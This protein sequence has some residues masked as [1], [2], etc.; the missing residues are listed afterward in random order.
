[1]S[2][3]CL[4]RGAVG[5]AL[6]FTLVAPTLARSA[7]K[8][9]E[10]VSAF[11]GTFGYAVPI[12]VPAFRGLE[13]RLGLAYTSEGRNGFAGVGWTLGGF[14]TVE[15]ANAGRGTPRFD[16]SDIY[17]LDGQE[18]LACTPTTASPSCTTGGTHATKIESYQRIKFDSGSNSWTATA[19]DGT[20][21]VFNPI[22]TTPHGTLRWG[23]SQRIDT[24]GNAVN[25]SWACV[26][27]DCYP[28]SASYNGYGITFYREP[29]P[30]VLSHGEV[31]TVAQTNRRLRT[32]LVHLGSTPIRGYKLS[33]SVSPV[34]GRSL[35]S[36]VTQ[37]GRDVVLDGA[38]AITGGSSLPPTT[39]TYQNDAIAKGFHPQGPNPPSPPGTTEPV[40][41]TKLE[42]A[43]A[44]T[45][46]NSLYKPGTVDA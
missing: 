2:R 13:P 36:S 27:G 4:R 9:S 37:Y 33:Y 31:S 29:R 23:V 46:G 26:D 20:R 6:L 15:R 5:P 38:G 11:H 39:F 34:T 22:V 25:Y 7:E 32:I 19:K 3:T 12:E 18:M 28:S 16:S 21:T 10:Q 30:D 14:S 44:W 41:W 45:P 35:L 1:M 43:Y 24:L 8:A 42:N 17:L 40:T